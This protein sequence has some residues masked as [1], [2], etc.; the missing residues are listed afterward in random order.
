MPAPPPSRQGG[1]HQ[2]T[3][4]RHQLIESREGNEMRTTS[5]TT[6]KTTTKAKTAAAGSLSA[7]LTMTLLLPTSATAAP[8]APA[9]ESNDIPGI[10]SEE[11]RE[12]VQRAGEQALEDVRIK[13]TPPGQATPA[14][15]A[16]DH[17]MRQVIADGAIGVSVRVNSPGL[18]WRGSAGKRAVDRNP[19]AGWQD[20]FR[21]ASNT[22]PMIATLVLQEV[23]RGAWTLDTTVDE[24]L[25]GLLPEHGD[26]TLR[27][28]LSHTSGMPNGTTELLLAQMSDPED[29]DEFRGLISRDYSQQDHVDIVNAFPW[30]ERG[31]FVYSNAGYVVLGML[32]EAQTG[33]S[34]EQLLR[35]RIWS[36][37]G[38]R[39]SAYPLNPGMP[40]PAL[41]EDAWIGDG[42]LGLRGFDPDLFRAAG[43]VVSTTGDLNSFTRSL[44]NGAL[45]DPAL[46]QEMATPVTAEGYGLGVYL[47]P[48]PCSSPEDPQWFIGHDG[49]SFGTLSVALT[50]ADGTRQISLAATGRDIS[51]IEPRWD[52][53]DVIVPA[54]LATC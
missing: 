17:G 36:P 4:G 12:Q 23:E 51:A 26:A 16:L 41:A 40:N 1:E 20:A 15:D 45:V 24:V 47:V 22:K 18:T 42:W 21:A 35:E 11:S 38:M 52:L 29:W 33:R 14:T 44:V 34:V 39:H 3:T 37:A 2:P 19:P 32:L 31:Q 27:E 48:D 10:T 50:S 46:V 30:T 9:E 7:L 54:L 5:T 53:G 28:L 43:A 25:P 6:N 49:A 13:G 8:T